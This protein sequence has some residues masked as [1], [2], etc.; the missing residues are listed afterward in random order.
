M[1][2]EEDDSGSS[3]DWSS[4]FKGIGSDLIGAYSKQQDN[5][6]KLKS[7]QLQLGMNGYYTEGMPTTG[8]QAR[9]S[10]GTIL[11]MGLAVVVVMM[12]KD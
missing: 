4:W 7:Q 1:D 5:A 3:S 9:N 12:L 11:L 6:Y 8:M 2:E 10:N